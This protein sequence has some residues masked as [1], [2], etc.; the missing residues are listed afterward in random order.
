MEDWKQVL[1]KSIVKPK[2]LAERFGLDEKEIEAIVGPYPMRI[3]PTVL[4]TI[5][6][7]DDAIWKQVVPERG[8]VGRYRGRRRSFRRRPHE[9]GASPRSPLSGPGVTHGDKSMPDLLSVLYQKAAGGKP[10][11]LKKG[12]LDRAIQYLRDHKEVRD[13]ILSGGD[14]LLLPDHLL[15][16]VLKALRTIPTWSS[17]GSARGSPGRCR[18]ASRPNSVTW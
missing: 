12:E 6:S 9:P 15:E 4:E 11:F 14:P 5:T 7:K 1:A 16:R 17:Y 3:T 8:G 13:V 2:D 18:N 10:G